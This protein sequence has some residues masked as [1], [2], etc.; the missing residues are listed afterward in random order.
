MP[1]R[2]KNLNT[3]NHIINYL[4]NSFEICWALIL[5]YMWFQ[6]SYY[7]MCSNTTAII[8]RGEKMYMGSDHLDFGLI[9]IVDGDVS[10][11]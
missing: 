7:S 4:V 5:R 6:Y 11:V 8:K 9:L 10:S 3:S 1:A 2:P